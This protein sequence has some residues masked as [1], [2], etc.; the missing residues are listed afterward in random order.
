MN[1]VNKIHV[2]LDDRSYDIHIGEKLHE[3]L[4]AYIPHELNIANHTVFIITDENVDK[5]HTQKYQQAISGLGAV[6]VHKY[7]LPAGEATKCFS[8]VENLCNWMLE[9]NVKRQS[10]VFTIG[11][12]VVGDIGAFAASIVMRGVSFIQVPT[13]LLSQVDS[14]VGGKTGI[15]TSHGKNLIGS[16][17]QPKAVLCD[18]STLETLPQREMLAG[19]AEV[20]KYGLIDDMEFFDWLCN[21]GEQVCGKNVDKLRYAIKKSCRS[22]ADLVAQDEREIGARALLNLGHTFGHA[23]ESVCGYDGTLL[24]GEAVAIGMVLAFQLSED[25][26]YCEDGCAVKIQ[27]HLKKV[28]LPTTAKEIATLQT[29]PEELYELMRGDKKATAKAINFIMAKG[30]G[31]SYITSEVSKDAVIRTL[32]ESL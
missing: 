19:Y 22:K 26:G 11:G 16:F 2:S 29:T 30:I 18:I 6:Q 32:K 21:N 20:V 24:H 1:A 12:G 8:N 10:I 14:S 7:V 17:Y 23:L 31:Q 3:N 13:T 15:N 5:H 27:E 25:L 9:N 4:N 28:G